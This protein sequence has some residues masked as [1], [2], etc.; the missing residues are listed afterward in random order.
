MYNYIECKFVSLDNFLVCRDQSVEDCQSLSVNATANTLPPKPADNSSRFSV[1]TNS[2]R[3]SMNSLETSPPKPVP[4]PVKK[5]V[6]KT[7]VPESR[8]LAQQ[9]RMVKMKGI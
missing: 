9:L 2:S 3:S 4:P 7:S 5:P 8:K 6:F 1:N